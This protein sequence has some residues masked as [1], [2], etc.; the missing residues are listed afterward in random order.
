MAVR[1]SAKQSQLK[2]IQFLAIYQIIKIEYYK[3]HHELFPIMPLSIR[4]N[5]RY[6]KK[7]L[8]ICCNLKKKE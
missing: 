3:Y 7:P 4:S 8:N 5:L 2:G 1:E 6:E